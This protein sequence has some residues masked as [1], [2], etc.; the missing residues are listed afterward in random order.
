[1]SFGSTSEKECS[2]IFITKWS[3]VTGERLEPK[4]YSSIYEENINRLESA[5]FPLVN[6]KDITTLISDG[7]HHTPSYTNS[8]V[9]FVSVKNV[10]KSF[11]NL[12]KTKFISEQ[13]AD[14]LDKRCKPKNGD[15]LLTKIGTYGYA[16]VVKSTERFQLFVSVALLRPKKVVLSDFL[17]IFLNSNLA[18]LQYHRVVKGSG[19][20]DLHL[21]DIRKIKM[22][23]PDLKNQKRVSEYYFKKLD[24]SRNK[25]KEANRLIESIDDILMKELGI[26]FIE[27]NEASNTNKMYFKNFSE[28]SQGRFDPLY[29]LGGIYTLLDKSTYPIVTLN[30][31]ISSLQSGFAAGKDEQSSLKEDIVQIRPTNISNEREFVFDKNVYIDRIKLEPHKKDLLKKGELLFNNTNSQ[32]LV[33]KTILFDLE[34][35]YFSSNHITRVKFKK[36]HDGRFYSHL[37]NCYQRNKVFFTLCTNWNNQSGISNDV[38]KNVKIPLIPLSEQVRIVGVIDRI[39]DKAKALKKEADSILDLTFKEVE[40]MILKDM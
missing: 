4:F 8:G 24:E 34:G 7:T 35:D 13:E 29:H 30:S 22:P 10:R 36:D 18:Y 40:Q 23:L 14:E 1:M 21:E 28:V 2:N 39:R 3:H 27:Q 9:K 31:V 16:S 32:E 17:E 19:V 26:P 11:I 37:F 12:E 20:P 38:L 15:V 6:L 25:E 33:G 5:D